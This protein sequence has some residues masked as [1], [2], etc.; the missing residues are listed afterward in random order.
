ME[1]KIANVVSWIFHP[2]FMPTYTYLILLT[3]NSF[4]AF[5]VPVN[6]KWGVTGFVFLI[7][8]VLPALVNYLFL[9]RGIIHSLMMETRQERFLPYLVSAACFYLTAYMA[10]M[11]ELPAVFYLFSLGITLLALMAVF[12]TF[13]M[14][15]SIHM[16][17][18]GG[19]TGTFLALSLRMHI[20]FL[21]V[22][23]V[24]FLLSGLLGY[25]RLQLHT[26]RPSEIYSGFLTGFGVMMILF[27]LI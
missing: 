26:H 4:I 16:V 25:A 13:Y 1:K 6:Q 12:L 17:G 22:I 19:V 21:A 23:L 11:L 15:V 3:G 24:S 5:S 10:K 8:A 9:K 2:L 27:L 18:I 7:T 14:K 20:D